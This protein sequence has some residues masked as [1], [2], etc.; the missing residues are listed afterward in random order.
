MRLIEIDP[1][2][3]RWFSG[4]DVSY[5]DGTPMPVY[6]ASSSAE[7]FTQFKPLTHFGTAKAANDRIR[8]G[9]A[10]T[11]DHYA[12]HA[13]AHRIYPVYLRIKNP[14]IINDGQYLNHTWT[15][16]AD[17]LCYDLKPKKL[18]ISAEE[19][20]SIFTAK[21]HEGELIRILQSKGYDGLVYQNIHEDPG[22][23]SWVV[24]DPATQVRSA[25]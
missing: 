19:R 23:L 24:F 3:K 16:I 9:K 6:H 15:T 10:L 21:D 1:E 2:F 20:A 8:D 12:D 25:I 18:R 5:T 17:M 11:S 7:E 22:S 14:L 13:N 4:S